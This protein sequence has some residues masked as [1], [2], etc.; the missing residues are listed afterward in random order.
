MDTITHGILGALIGKAYFAEDTPA[1]PQ[2]SG[3]GREA[4]ATTS[5][6]AGRAGRVAIFAA[7]LGAIFP[8]GDVLLEPLSHNGLGILEIHRGFTHSFVGLPLFAVALAALTSWIARRRGWRAPS[9]GRLALI[10]AIAL[11]SH[12]LLDLITS[13]GTMIW[14]PLSHARAAWDLAFIIDFSM[15]AIVIV[16]QLI[17][18]VFR[19]REA[20]RGRALGI[21]LLASAATV[22]VRHLLRLVG[23]PFSARVAAGI[24]ALLAALFFL[25]TWNGWG[26]RIRRARW[27]RTGVYALATYLLLLAVAH[28]AALRRVEQFAAAR[29]LCVER[30]GALPL[31]PS[32]LQWDGLIRTADGVYEGQFDLRRSDPP[33][34]RFVADARENSYIEAARQQPDVKVYLWF[35]RFPVVRFADEG[36]RKVVEFADLRFSPRG[37]RPTPFTF[38][39]TL[40]DSGRVL[41]QGWAR[42]RP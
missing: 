17:A 26:F 24:V 31:P 35:A 1:A 19:R 7:T 39:V 27:C 25:P 41:K 4:G 15:T 13:F 22:G 6:S 3:A 8:D 38:R 37:R 30:L 14:S 12:V 20:S 40:D 34:F 23:F 32:G 36:D 10:Y 33:A 21:W 29:G 42:A 18:W 16:P 5:A 28:A 2:A 9:W 11:G